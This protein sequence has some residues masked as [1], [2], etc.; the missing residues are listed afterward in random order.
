MLFEKLNELLV[1]SMK[2][3]DK[4]RTQTLKLI[5]AKFLEARVAKGRDASKP[6]SDSE[7][8]TILLKMSA[9]R[10]ESAKQYTEGG[11]P[12]LA[13][14]EMAEVKIIDEFLPSTPEPEEV[15]SF[16]SSIWIEGSTMKDMGR[17]VSALKDQ[18]P[19]LDGKTIS[20]IV[21]SRILGK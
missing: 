8:C 13:E 18:F 1:S 12:E 16:L 7:E 3:G 19:G 20:G 11:R 4:T 15:E 6:L 17:Y 9:E 5:K 21:K 14:A 2:A 10:I